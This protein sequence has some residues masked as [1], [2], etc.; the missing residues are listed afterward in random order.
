MREDVRRSPGDESTRIPRPGTGPGFEASARL[1]TLVEVADY[2]RV[3][4]KTIR[5]LV[6]GRKLPCIRL[7]RVLRFQPAD[8]DRWVEARKE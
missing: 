2:L 7:G 4:A 3:S 1:M 8:V 6:A 5:R